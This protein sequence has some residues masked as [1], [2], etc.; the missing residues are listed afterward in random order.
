MSADIPPTLQVT[1]LVL[2]AT[3]GHIPL[4]LVAWCNSVRLTIIPGGY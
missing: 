1:H 4:I 2:G 3:L